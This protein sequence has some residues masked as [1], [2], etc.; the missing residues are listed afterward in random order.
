M[1]KKGE[2]LTGMVRSYLALYVLFA[3]LALL[4]GFLS[5]P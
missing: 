2:T 5:S 4:V 1:T 3:L